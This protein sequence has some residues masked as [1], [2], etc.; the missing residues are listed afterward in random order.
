MLD[1]VARALRRSA[2]HAKSAERGPAAILWPDQSGQW[3]VAAEQLRDTLPVVEL[4]PYRPGAWIGPA[5][6]VRCI[7][8]GTLPIPVDGIPIVYLPGYA[9]SDIRAVEDAHHQLKPLAE[10]QYRGVIFS[11]KSGRDWTLLAF[12]QAAEARGGLGL[13][14]ASDEGTKAALLRAAD[15]VLSEPVDRLRRSAP[16]KAKHFDA[17]MTPDI[18]RDVLHWLDDPAGHR[19]G[20]SAEQ[21]AS[22]QAQFAETFGMELDA[23]AVAVASA[24]GARASQEWD[25]VWRAFADAPNRYPGVPDRLR[26]ARPKPK[27]SQET[28]GLWD[29]RGTWPQDNEEAE[30]VLRQRLLGLDGESP[31]SARATIRELDAVAGER[32]GWVWAALGS[33]PLAFACEHLATLARETDSHMAPGSVGSITDAY[34]S[35][36]WRA[37]DAVMRAIAA[38]ESVDDAAAVGVAVRTIYMP[39]LEVAAERLASAVRDDPG[40]Y[41]SPAPL[42]WPSGTCVI[43]TDGLR[44]DLGLRLASVLERAGLEATV[45]PR[46][47]ALPSITP[48]AKPAVTPAVSRLRAGGV[49]G[50]GAITGGADLTADGLRREIRESGYQT[51][52]SDE[53]GDPS[54]RGWGEQGD[55]DALGH[56]HQARL[57]ALIDSEIAKLGARIRTLLAAGWKQVVV[58][59]DH[60]WL[61]LPGGLPKAELPLHATKD[62]GARKGRAARL[63]DGAVVTVQTVP[64]HWDPTV[65]IGIAPGIR[66]FTGSPVYEHGGISPQ[67]CVT[68]VVI[69]RPRGGRGGDV[70]IEVAWAGLRARVA[71]TGTKPGW[72]ADI[73]TV[74]GKADSTVVGGRRDLGDD[75]RATFPVED[76]DLV[77]TAAFAVVV[78]A[79]DS[80]IAEESVVIGGED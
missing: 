13:E 15:R 66:V 2:D 46:L 12:L 5:Y 35:G 59:T 32:R 30:Q 22:F 16:L 68:P 65:Q 28:P 40:S 6:W 4:G 71:V 73:R 14:V 37:D 76:D 52:A 54:G 3:R 61:Y 17:L 25:R 42:P 75:G 64:W 18:E 26:S 63:A 78:D 7:V 51:L 80:V 69:A 70:T 62:G 58:V 50:V 34:V 77:G 67:E 33:A 11:Q 36:R 48:T 39:W 21:W 55:I 53:L 60:G 8:D 49:F 24:L 43:F 41:L 27:K 47:T 1:A 79:D 74:A 44:F 19:A 56:E 9:R 72:S 57:P 38:V 20:L 45:E 23:G 10:L 29:A 31:E